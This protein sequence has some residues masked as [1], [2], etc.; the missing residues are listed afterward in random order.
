[1]PAQSAHEEAA[2]AT[3]PETVEDA[4][5]ET[6]GEPVPEAIAEPAAEEGQIEEPVSA[7]AEIVTPVSAPEAEDSAARARHAAARTPADAAVV[8][9]AV[10]Q[11]AA[12][13]APAET[14]PVA[15][16]TGETLL[17]QPFPVDQGLVD[18]EVTAPP[19]ATTPSMVE[20]PVAPT[21]APVEEQSPVP[22]DEG[23]QP[24][25][26]GVSAAQ[27]PSAAGAEPDDDSTSEAVIN[28]PATPAPQTGSA[29]SRR[30]RHAAATAQTPVEPD[31]DV[32]VE[33]EV[34]AASDA[35]AP[36]Q[37]ASSSG[38]VESAYEPVAIPAVEHAGD[39]P[40][41]A[42][43]GETV[44]PDQS[45]PA[46]IGDAGSESDQT[47]LDLSKEL[48]EPV[49][50]EMPRHA[51]PAEGAVPP[52]AEAEGSEPVAAPTVSTPED[53]PEDHAAP[54]GPVEQI[55]VANAEQAENSE[56]SQTPEVPV[57]AAESEEPAKPAESTE[58]VEA[59]EAP[60]SAEAAEEEPAEP[61]PVPWGDEELR[62]RIYTEVQEFVAAIARRDVNELASRYGISGNDL[63]GLDEQ[64]AVLS[65]PAADL[66]LYPVEQA[67]D[68]VDGHHRLGLSELE[69]G[70][71][72]I[73]SELWAHEA[74]T[75]ARLNA[76]WNPMGIYPFDFRNVSM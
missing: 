51:V 19:A 3:V 10:E 5:A 16:P 6:D 70:G 54:E 14:E 45:E 2:S 29:A 24:G 8:A 20:M 30:A 9:D 37:V 1:M 44:A 66:A 28:T 34:E 76:H 63:A 25:E 42:P 52:V 53:D 21:T 49:Q 61:T 15:A 55:D 36:T 56:S 4:P 11:P 26:I 18:G 60:E 50:A 39:E 7:E 48:G 72:V 27:T 35:A 64:L 67:D 71:V 17:V 73:T 38:T 69:G 32:V 43:T 23:D 65:I 40:V 59:P 33:G 47:T 57:E 31:A 46:P 68:Y 22:V 12:P 74:A 58:A 13:A 62:R 75:G 41:A